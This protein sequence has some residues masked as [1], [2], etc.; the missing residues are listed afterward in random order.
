[1]TTSTGISL[2]QRQKQQTRE[3]LLQAAGTLFGKNGYA[4]TSID[5]IVSEAG[6]SRATLYAYFPSKDALLAEIVERMWADAQRYYEAFG[7]LPDWS[8][9]SVLQWMRS[10][11]EAWQRDAARNQAAAVA[12]FPT[13]FAERPVRRRAQV[14]AL[15]ANTSLWEHFGDSEADLR[16]SMVVT[17]VENEFATYFFEGA[18]LDLDV[19]LGYVT[20]AVRLL[21]AASP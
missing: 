2:R 9:R 7:E 17:V 12:A 4:A 5:D 8:R 11:A 21:L 3:H 6:A 15:R 18:T 1:M 13:V 14:N 10:F 16:A 19:F 20:D